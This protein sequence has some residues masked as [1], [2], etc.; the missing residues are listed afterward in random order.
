MIWP[1]LTCW[2]RT[3]PRHTPR[4]SRSQLSVALYA[5]A[6]LVTLIVP[7]ISGGDRDEWPTQPSSKVTQL[8]TSRQVGSFHITVSNDSLSEGLNE[9]RR[10]RGRASDSRNYLKAH[11][12]ET[13]LQDL[14][15]SLNTQFKLSSDINV[16]FEIC[17]TP[18]SF[19]DDSTNKITICKEMIDEFYGLF[20]Q[21]RIPKEELRQKV[22]DAIAFFFM[23][24]AGH[25]LVSVLDLPIAGREEDAVD[26]FSVLTLLRTEPDG[27]RMVLAGAESFNLYAQWARRTRE[28]RVYWDE[29]SQDEQRYFDTLCLVYGSDPS[30]FQYLVSTGMLPGER[31]EICPDEY[32][33]ASRSWVTLLKDFEKSSLNSGK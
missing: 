11:S 25:A 13:T 1:I 8:N 21:S 9:R 24:E 18:D 7:R 23:H 16:S 31:A 29:H 26:Q 19:F 12:I 4:P 27:S 14:T 2:K 5:L 32:A 20:G 33:R 3:V 10:R 30:A 28:P 15:S 17:K 6:L 22:N